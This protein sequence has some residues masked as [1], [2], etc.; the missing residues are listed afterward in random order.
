MAQKAIDYRVEPVE[1][2]QRIKAYRIRR[3]LSVRDME[4]FFGV[5][6]QTVY[7]WERGETLP[8]FDNLIAL[9]YFLG[10]SAHVLLTGE[11]FAAA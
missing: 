11:E 4:E 6:P 3:K 8:N 9:S 2:G 1:V 5:Y 7:K 10:V